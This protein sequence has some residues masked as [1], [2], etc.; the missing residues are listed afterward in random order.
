MDKYPYIIHTSTISGNFEIIKQNKN[1][2]FIITIPA[3]SLSENLRDSKQRAIMQVFNKI[4]LALN[5]QLKE[6]LNWKCLKL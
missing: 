4:K 5:P 6:F 3:Y 2:Q 1:R